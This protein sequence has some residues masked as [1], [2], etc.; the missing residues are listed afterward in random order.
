MTMIKKWNKKTTWKLDD[1]RTM[2]VTNS[3][4]ISQLH[5]KIINPISPS[6]STSHWSFAYYNGIVGNTSVAIGTLILH[7]IT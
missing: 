2:H 6:D 7:L 1:G 4:S 3:N 5:I